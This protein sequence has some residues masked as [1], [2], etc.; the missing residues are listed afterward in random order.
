[1]RR[2]RRVKMR[3]HRENYSQIKHI[4]VLLKEQIFVGGR[5]RIFRRLDCAV[6]KRIGCFYAMKSG[7][8]KGVGELL[9]AEVNVAR[10]NIRS[11]KLTAFVEELRE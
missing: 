6:V 2:H 4:P 3:K 10:H 5:S 1:M 7:V 9:S 8:W 11:N